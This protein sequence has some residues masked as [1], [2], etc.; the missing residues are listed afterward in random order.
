MQYNIWTSL[1]GKKSFLET[2]KCSD[3]KSNKTFINSFSNSNIYCYCNTTKMVHH[4]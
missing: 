2:G 4:S 1:L 3:Y